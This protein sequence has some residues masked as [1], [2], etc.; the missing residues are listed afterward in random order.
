M[1]PQVFKLR[2]AL[3]ARSVTRQRRLSTA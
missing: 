1:R 3:D 2:R